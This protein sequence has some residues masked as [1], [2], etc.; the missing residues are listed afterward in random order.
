MPLLTRFWQLTDST[1][2]TD[3]AD[4]FTQYVEHFISYPALARQ[5]GLGG[6][7]YARLTVQPD[8]RVGSI[9]ITRRDLSTASPPIK[10]V[11]ALDAELQRVAWQLRFKPAVPSID[12]TSLRPIARADTVTNI[13]AEGDSTETVTVIQVEDHDGPTFLAD[14]VTI[15]YR[16][17]PQ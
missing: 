16:F 13:V 1:E 17:V 6:A 4:V 9:S 14:T 5:A 10:A 8:G 2:R 11:M 7:I 3:A 12:S 15:S